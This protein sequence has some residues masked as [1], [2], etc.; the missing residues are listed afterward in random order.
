MLVPGQFSRMLLCFIPVES[1]QT[2][3]P[4]PGICDVLLP[5]LCASS[6]L[7]NNAEIQGGGSLAAAAALG[8]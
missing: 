8:M 6:P 2:T 5:G 1:G 7:A 4:A 3:E